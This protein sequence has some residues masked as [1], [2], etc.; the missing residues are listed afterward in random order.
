MEWG[1]AGVSIAILVPYCSGVLFALECL[2]C[3]YVTVLTVAKKLML[4]NTDLI[5]FLFAMISFILC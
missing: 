5:D 1:C 2:L 4:L 3:I